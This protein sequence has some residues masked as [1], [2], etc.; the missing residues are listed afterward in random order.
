MNDRDMVL[1]VIAQAML[2]A[3]ERARDTGQFLRVSFVVEGSSGRI[4][5]IVQDIAWI[6]EG[7]ISYDNGQPGI[8]GRFAP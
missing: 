5:P 3:M 7:G 6:S 4:A 1:G 8:V 2:Q